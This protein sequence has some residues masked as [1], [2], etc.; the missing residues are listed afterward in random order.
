MEDNLKNI[1]KSV[2]DII[3]WFDEDN[4]YE[5]EDYDNKMKELQNLFNPLM[6]KMYSQDDQVGKES[7]N[8]PDIQEVD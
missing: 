3:K 7:E 2:D 8:M 1:K 4:N 5:K 6:S